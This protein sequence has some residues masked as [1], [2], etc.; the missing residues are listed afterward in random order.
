MGWEDVKKVV[1][2]QELGNEKYAIP[3]LASASWRTND[4]E[5]KFLADL[6]LRQS[7]NKPSTRQHHNHVARHRREVELPVHRKSNLT[8]EEVENG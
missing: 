7:T 3:L 1:A 4:E 2:L 6:Q 8:M 5:S